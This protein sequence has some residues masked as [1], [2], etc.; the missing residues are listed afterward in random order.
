V[1]SAVDSSAIVSAS[2]YFDESTIGSIINKNGYFT[3][4]I[5]TATT[6]PLV[7][8]SLGYETLILEPSTLKKDQ[9]FV[10]YLTESTEQL[11]AVLLETDPWSRN[12]K[13]TEFKKEFLGK[14]KNAERCTILNEEVLQLRYSRSRQN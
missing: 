14:T 7:I 3:I 4:K 9:K 10:F 12:K 8:S 6:N 1:R 11:G 5:T 13:L 2:I